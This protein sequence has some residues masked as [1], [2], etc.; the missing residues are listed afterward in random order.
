MNLDATLTVQSN[1]TDQFTIIMS[2]IN[3][4]FFPMKEMVKR[5]IPMSSFSLYWYRFFLQVLALTSNLTNLLLK[6]H[7]SPSEEMTATEA[8][9]GEFILVQ[10]FT[11]Y[12][13]KHPSLDDCL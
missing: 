9:I 4:T 3:C 1:Q 5:I 12:R 11:N 8:T 7:V 13:P 6:I 10:F 2:V